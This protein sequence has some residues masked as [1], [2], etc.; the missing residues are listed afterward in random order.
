LSPDGKIVA[1]VTTGGTVR[2]RDTEG[3]ERWRGEPLG[4]VY[5]LAFAPDGKTLATAT[6]YCIVLWDVATG[7]RLTPT[8][9]PAAGVSLLAWSPDGET[10]AVA[11]KDGSVRRWDTRTWQQVSENW[12][13]KGARIRAL[14]LVTER[15]LL[16][17]IEARY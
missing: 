10:L 13:G 3:K 15:K 14:R 8:R 5:S 12:I 9:E 6:A 17:V 1:S 2:C 16:A 4:Y 7:R 11:H